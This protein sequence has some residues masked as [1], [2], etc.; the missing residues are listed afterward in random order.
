MEGSTAED[1]QRPPPF[2]VLDSGAMSFFSIQLIFLR[3]THVPVGEPGQ[4]VSPPPQRM[5]PSEYVYAWSTELQ[6]IHS[7]FW[8]MVRAVS[9]IC[10][11]TV[12]D[13]RVATER[14][15][16]LGTVRGTMT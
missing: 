2:H 15:D 5:C 4:Q 14:I 7:R 11:T 3:A 8:D 6:K 10:F 9:K 1:S 12:V 16:A 13:C